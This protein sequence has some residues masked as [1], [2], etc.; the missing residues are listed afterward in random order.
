MVSGRRVD[1][2]ENVVAV[3][4][5]IAHSLQNDKRDRIRATV[6]VS[7]VIKRLALTR[8]R[9]EEAAVKLWSGP[10]DQL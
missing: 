6:A 8:G 2:R 7:L 4:D 9:E 10:E 1:R 5:S 3:S